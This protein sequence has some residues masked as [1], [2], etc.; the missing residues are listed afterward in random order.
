MSLS[1]NSTAPR[2]ASVTGATEEVVGDEEIP[3][4]G[5]PGGVDF[6]DLETFGNLSAEQIQQVMAQLQAQLDLDLAGVGLQQANLGFQRDVGMR[7]IAQSQLEGLQAAERNA[8]QRGI[9]NSGI[10]VGNQQEVIKQAG[11]AKADLQRGITL[12]LQQLQLQ[13]AQLKNQFAMGVGQAAYDIGLADLGFYQNML[14]QNNVSGYGGSGG[15]STADNTNPAN[16]AAAKAGEGPYGARAELTRSF[17]AQWRQQ[18][19]GIAIQGDGHFRP[20]AQSQGNGRDP[21]SDH[22]T[23]GALDIFVRTPQERAAFNAWYQ[24]VWPQLQSQGIIAEYVEVGGNSAHN[25]HMHISF[26]LVGPGAASANP[27][28]AVAEQPSGGGRYGRN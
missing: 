12:G 24:S 2:T 17:A 26:T 5:G 4:P 28:G 1:L 11:E 3:V 9:F 10:R 21:N 16:I 27:G 18:F 19:P 20:A 8:L 25:D 23:G 22:I 13:V 6:A 15:G 14:G 7:E